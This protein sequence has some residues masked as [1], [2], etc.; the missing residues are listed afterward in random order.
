ME[1]PHFFEHD[2]GYTTA[3]AL[4]DFGAQFYKQRFNITPLDVC[5][6]RAGEDQFKSS[7]VLALHAAIVPRSGTKLDERTSKRPTLT[8]SGTQ[9]APRCG[10]LLERRLLMDHSTLALAMKL[11]TKL[12]TMDKKLLRAFPKRAIALSAG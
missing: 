6:C 8:P 4:A 5:A 12:I 11:D 3:L 10:N 2:H 9:H 1:Y 7:L